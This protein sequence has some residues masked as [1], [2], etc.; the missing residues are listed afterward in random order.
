MNKIVE[1]TISIKP[2]NVK[3][4]NKKEI[5]F[6]EIEINE[7]IYSLNSFVI[8]ENELENELNVRMITSIK[9]ATETKKLVMTAI[10]LKTAKETM[11]SRDNVKAKFMDLYD[12]HENELLIETGLDNQL[13]PETIIRQCTVLNSK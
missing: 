3:Q 9:V 13:L 11:L 12:M 7:N 10:W 6:N 8:V 4:K 2:F 5:Y 1:K